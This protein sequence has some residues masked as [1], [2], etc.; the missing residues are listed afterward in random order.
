M[1]VRLCASPWRLSASA[2][3]GFMQPRTVS[4]FGKLFTPK[5]DLN[6]LSEWVPFTERIVKEE[7]IQYEIE[8]YNEL[9]PESGSIG[10]TL[11]IEF[12]DPWE[13]ASAARFSGVIALNFWIFIQS[14][15]SRNRSASSCSVSPTTKPHLVRSRS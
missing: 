2:L 10:A 4:P 1:S 11:M 13:R 12:T 9:I 3:A 14:S 5:T 6:I 8:T 7:A 15:T